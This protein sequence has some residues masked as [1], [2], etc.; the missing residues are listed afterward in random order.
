MRIKIMQL[1]VGSI[2]L[3]NVSCVDRIDFPVPSGSSQ[4]IIEGIITNGPPP[5]LVKVSRGIDL[6]ADSLSDTGYS[7]LEVIL[8]EDDSGTEETLTEIRPGE[9][10]SAGV[11]Q[12]TIG[13]TYH[14]EVTTP[15]GTKFTSKPDILY[16]VGEIDSIKI[17]FESR[18]DVLDFG[19]VGADVF[20]VLVDSKATN[21]GDGFVRWRFQGTYKVITEPQKFMIQYPWSDDPRRLPFECSGYVVVPNGT[22][23]GGL[24]SVRPC[25]CCTC[26]ANDFEPYPQ[27]SDGALV[28]NN[29]FLNVKVGEVPIN[30]STFYD[31]YLIKV[32]QMS[33]SR[34][35]FNFFNLVRAQ[36]LGA[37]DFFQ[38]PIGEIIGNISASDNTVVV[39]I[40]WASAVQTKERFLDK[41]D[42]PYPI[43]E[44]PFAPRPCYDVYPNATTIEPEGWD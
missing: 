26:W 34:D 2:L 11:I 28:E 25:E 21:S 22:N 36:Q 14:I 39:G 3:T 43:G 5:Y 10:E 4:V 19:E 9:Y 40:F 17:E 7:G 31:K 1:L 33:M 24:E 41:S 15:E 37:T 20:N 16:P 27:L 6:N 38:P 44:I 23:M 12:G 29:E 42:V 8:Y 13:N 35:A 32:E 30:N 18:T